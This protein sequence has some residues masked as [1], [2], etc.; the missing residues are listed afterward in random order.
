MNMPNK[1]TLLRV[2]LVPV[3]IIISVIP[4]LNDNFIGSTSLTIAN[5]INLIIFCVASATDFLDGHLARKYNQVTT[6]GKFADPLADKMLVI[7]SLLLLMS[8]YLQ[9]S[10]ANDFRAIVPAWAVSIIVIRELMVSGIRLVAAERGEVIAAG[11]SGKVKTAFTMVTIILCFLCGAFEAKA[12]VIVCQIA[13]YISVALTI[14][15]GAVYLFRSR[16]LIFESI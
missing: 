16:K 15:S 2:I 9:N 10:A 6:F 5:L 7:T 8:D 1:L 13:L 4:F 11:W 14:Y 3:M 12:F